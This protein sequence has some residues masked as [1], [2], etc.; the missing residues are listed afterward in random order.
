LAWQLEQSGIFIVWSAHELGLQ[1]LPEQRSFAASSGNRDGDDPCWKKIWQST[2]P[3]KVKIFAWK[4]A[5][6]CLATKENKL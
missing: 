6:D 3:P 5:F 2:V 4:A 1:E